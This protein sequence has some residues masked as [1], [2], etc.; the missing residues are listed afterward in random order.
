MRLDFPYSYSISLGE[1]KCN[2]LCRM[3]P[4]YT[5][6]PQTQR[7]ISDEVLDR[8][9]RELG[10]RPCSLE[11]SA[12]GET[13]LHPKSDEYL[14]VARQ[15]CPNAYIVVATNGTMLDR[16]RCERIVDSGIDYL[17]FSLD[18]GSAASY[19]WLTGCDDYEAVCGNLETLVEVRNQRGADHLTIGTHI[20]GIKELSHEFDA[21]VER[22]TGVADNPVVRNYGN[23]AGI[24]DHN[25]VTPAEEQVI[26]PQRYPCAWLW[27][28]TKIEP[29]GDVSK[30]FIHVT[31][32][33]APLGNIMEQGF[34]EIWHGER[35][36]QLREL[37]CGNRWDEIEFCP[38]CMVWSLFP[39]FWERKRRFGLLGRWRWT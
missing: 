14:R 16:Q 10:D 2:R 39:Q 20:I 18:A 19:K 17:S 21:F 37:H 38:S 22:W 26:P 31:G 15:L 28:A 5:I 9:C 29:N 30:C 25:E 24:I 3:C 36:R 6:P 11:I 23:W 8:A 13:F 33:K 1:Y 34:E 7:Y 32:D 12:Y 35:I 4:M 27:F